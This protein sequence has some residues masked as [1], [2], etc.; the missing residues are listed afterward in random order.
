MGAATWPLLSL[1]LEE[2]L[3]LSSRSLPLSPSL[4]LSSRLL[5]FLPSRLR[6]RSCRD[7]LCFLSRLRDRERDLSLFLFFSFLCFFLSSLPP[8]ILRVSLS[9]EPLLDRL[10]LT[11]L[12]RLGLR[13]VLRLRR[14]S[15]RPSRERDR[16]ELLLL[17][18]D[19]LSFFALLPPL[20]SPLDR[21]FA[22]LSESLP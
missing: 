22:S 8:R 4:S 3:L 10:L 18:L 17:D 14:E 9:S 2:T 12:P 16:D 6:L 5:F 7:R 15:F 1:Q 11:L 13:L 19:R 21:P 20:P